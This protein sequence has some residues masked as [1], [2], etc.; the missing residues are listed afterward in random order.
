MKQVMP[1]FFVAAVTLLTGCA[2]DPNDLCAH[3]EKMY[4]TAVD[5]PAFLKSRDACIENFEMRKKRNGVNS[6]RREAECI[7]NARKVFDTR[8]CTAKE[9]HRMRKV[10]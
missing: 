2:P 8:E 1:F 10:S 9:D 3:L 5:P 7:L 6:Y 4:K